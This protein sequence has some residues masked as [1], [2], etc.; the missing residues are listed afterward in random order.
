MEL[1]K[2]RQLITTNEPN[3][4]KKVL[5]E[6]RFHLYPNVKEKTVSCCLSGKKWAS[7]FVE[8]KLAFYLSV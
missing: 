3:F 7:A 5:L 4:H 1:A 6:A 2:T 8:S